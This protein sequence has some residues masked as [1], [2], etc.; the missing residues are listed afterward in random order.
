MTAFKNILIGA[1][2]QG[3]KF[4]LNFSYEQENRETLN[5]KHEHLNNYTKVSF[6]GTLI[7]KYGSAVYD[8][9]IRSFGQ[10]MDEL[11]RIT[12]PAKGYTLANIKEIYSFWNRYHL[13]DLNSHCEHQDKAIKWDEVTPCPV[14]GYKAGSNWLVQEITREEL[15]YIFLKVVKPNK[16]VA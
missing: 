13:N 9:G 11:L 7:S 10:N 15:D 5:I 14:T 2:D 1:N 4:F 12:H 8:R 3:E 16:A 6:S